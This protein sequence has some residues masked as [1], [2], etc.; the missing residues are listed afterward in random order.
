MNQQNVTTREP[1]PF[2]PADGESKTSVAIAVFA[3][4]E[5][6]GIV[7]MLEGIF[8]QNLFAELARRGQ[9]AQVVC[10]V[11]GSSDRTAEVARE[12]LER[13]TRQHPHR[14]GFTATVTNLVQRG[15]LN[16]WN[17]F[18]YSISAEEATALFLM[19]ADIKIVGEGA[20]W[21]MLQTLQANPEVSI[22]TDRPQKHIH[23]KQR[24]NT[25][26][27]LSG[28]MSQ[29]TS[30]S[31]VQLCGQLY[32]IRADVARRIYLPKDLAACED[33]FLK[34]LVCT[35]FLT[36]DVQPHRIQIADEAAHTFEAYLSPTAVLRNQKRQVIGQTIV[37]LLVD[38]YLPTW[39]DSDRGRMATRLRE[40][41][42]NDPVWLKRLIAEHLRR[43]R[44]FWRLYP[45]LLHYRFQCW[46]QLSWK[47]RV[48]CFPATLASFFVLLCASFLAWRALRGGS[49]NYWPKA[50]R[51]EPRSPEEPRRSPV[52]ESHLSPPALEASTFKSN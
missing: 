13:V 2:S 4:N 38:R 39:S 42:A 48:I 51:T 11:N 52:L 6:A 15:K 31:P 46:K 32:C 8:R 49:T 30:S 36:H 16:A 24:K 20:L 41:D 1:D 21:N 29:L 35:D 7:D 5:E 43:T 33:G 27:K 34:A 25:A 45:D 14:S 50:P 10:V 22:S 44:F 28:G 19:D 3:W 12:L 40:Q 23:A 17:Q 47:Q 37:H 9:R 26:E 18:V